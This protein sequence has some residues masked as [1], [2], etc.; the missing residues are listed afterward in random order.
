MKDDELL[1]P[2]GMDRIAEQYENTLRSKQ[3]DLAAEVKK[4]RDFEV[5]TCLKI[6]KNYSN[7]ERNFV[8]N[9]LL[10]LLEKEML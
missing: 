4:A 2:E 3:N 7:T 6:L 9:Y 1:T 10:D 8:A 5:Y